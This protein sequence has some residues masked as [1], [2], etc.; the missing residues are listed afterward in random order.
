MAWELVTRQFGNPTWLEKSTRDLPEASGT[1]QELVQACIQVRQAQMRVN[2]KGEAL[3]ELGKPRC[4]LTLK[5]K[6]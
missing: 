3:G 6:L 5:G 1:S 4:K 2:T